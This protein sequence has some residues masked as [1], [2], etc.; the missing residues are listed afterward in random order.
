MEKLLGK[1]PVTAKP[2]SKPAQAT[3]TQPGEAQPRAIRFDGSVEEIFRPN[4]PNPTPDTLSPEPNAFRSQ[5]LLDWGLAM[6]D[7]MRANV[8][9]GIVGSPEARMQNEIL[10]RVLGQLERTAGP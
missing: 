5:Y 10:G 6:E 8:E 4:P 3:P 7:A 1:Q 9:G 2:S